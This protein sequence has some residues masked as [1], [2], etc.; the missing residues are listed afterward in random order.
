MCIHEVFNIA[1][2]LVKTPILGQEE[3]SLIKKMGNSGQRKQSPLQW[4]PRPRERLSLVNF[5]A[6]STMQKGNGARWEQNRK[7]ERLFFNKLILKKKHTQ[8]RNHT[9]WNR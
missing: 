6:G 4:A 7:E 1:L 3:S 8:L 5:K 9:T 2:V